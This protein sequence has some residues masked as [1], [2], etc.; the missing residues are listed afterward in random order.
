MSVEKSKKSCAALVHSHHANEVAENL[1]YL[2]H[3]IEII[4]FL[5]RQGMAYRGDN[6]NKTTS[7]NLG[8]FLELLDFHCKF[9]PNLKE[10][11]ES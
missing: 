6:E 4:H 8:N 5:A 10:K 11:S 7:N 2:K 1:K 9:I 3:I